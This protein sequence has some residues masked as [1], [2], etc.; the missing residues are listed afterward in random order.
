MAYK[1]Q[2]NKTASKAA[3]NTNTN[4]KSKTT[5]NKIEKNII[6]SKPVEKAKPKKI[7]LTEDDLVKVKSSCFGRLFYKNKK[8][9]ETF[10]WENPDDIQVMS[11]R[12][13][14]S[15]RAEQPT[16]FKNQ[17]I[18]IV[19]MVDESDCDASV[20]DIYKTLL[21]TRQGYIDIDPTDYK[22]VCSWTEKEIKEYVSKMSQGAQNNLIVSLNT[23]IEKGY[24]DS[25]KKIKT[26]EEALNCELLRK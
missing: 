4:T 21:I 10:I 6:E 26:F 18:K 1:K 13:L 2:V 3:T 15:M 17:W 22:S 20:E 11:I 23:F 24:L 19:G 12:E 5:K 14:R 16:F 7:K 25:V 8:N 9:S